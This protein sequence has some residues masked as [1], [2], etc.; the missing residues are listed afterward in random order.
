M[1]ASGFGVTP[2]AL[3]THAG[4]IEALADEVATAKAAGNQLQLG[5]GAYGVLCTS[6]P[7]II[8]FLQGLVISGLDD[9]NQSLRHTGEQLRAT[10]RQYEGIEDSVSTDLHR[11]GGGR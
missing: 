11:A 6:V 2:D 3:V 10:A 5:S 7:I 1:S 8:G 9:A 4:R